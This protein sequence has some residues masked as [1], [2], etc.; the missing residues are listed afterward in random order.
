MKSRHKEE[1][2]LNVRLPSA[3]PQHRFNL[4]S[5]LRLRRAPVTVLAERVQNLTGFQANVRL[6]LSNNVV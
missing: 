1:S 3:H 4:L 6:A 5:S 2:T